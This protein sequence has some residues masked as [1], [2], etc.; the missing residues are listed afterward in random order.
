LPSK[1][2]VSGWAWPIKREIAAGRR[3][4]GHDN[5][6]SPFR[7]NINEAI[8]SVSRFQDIRPKQFLLAHKNIIVSHKP[9]WPSSLM[10]NKMSVIVPGVGL[11]SNTNTEAHST[12]SIFH[13]LSVV[14]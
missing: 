10:S 14:D 7:I 2:D 13:T 9:T 5:A 3:K 12:E 6:D 11:V 4:Q 8:G 1:T